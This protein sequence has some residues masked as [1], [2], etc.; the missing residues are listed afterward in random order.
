MHANVVVGV[1]IAAA[2]TAVDFVTVNNVVVVFQQQM[3]HVI[4]NTI[5]CAAFITVITSQWVSIIIMVC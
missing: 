5:G 1:I 4:T 3:L 2:G